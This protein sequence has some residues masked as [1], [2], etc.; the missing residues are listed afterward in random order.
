MV[1]YIARMDNRGKG[2]EL[3]RVFDGDGLPV[4]RE[5]VPAKFR[6]WG[7]TPDAEN[8]SPAARRRREEGRAMTDMPPAARYRN[9][10]ARHFV[11]S[12]PIGPEQAGQ[13]EAALGATVR[14]TFAAWGHPTLWA[15]HVEHGREIHGHVIIKNL[16]DSGGRL[17]M[18]R[19]GAVLDGLR[20]TLARHCR[21]VGLD[22]EATRRA[23]RPEM[24]RGLVA[25]GAAPD[26]ASPWNSEGRQPI[27]ERLRE[28]APDWMVQD[29]FT[30][31][32]RIAARGARRRQGLP[33]DP[34]R[35][36]DH[37]QGAGEP[38]HPS[39]HHVADGL[40][41]YEQLA[42]RLQAL[43]VFRN[44]EDRDRTWQALASFDRLRREEWWQRRD[45][46]GRRAQR[47]PFSNWM[48]LNQPIA[49]G[50]VTSAARRMNR[51]AEIR[52]A[53]AALPEPGPHQ[54]RRMAGVVGSDPLSL[55]EQLRAAEA[56]R[57]V[58][59]SRR[60]LLVLAR[61]LELGFQGDPEAL[62]RAIRLRDLGHALETGRGL[63]AAPMAG[64][65]EAAPGQPI[66]GRDDAAAGGRGQDA[67]KPTD[68][69]REDRGGL[70]ADLDRF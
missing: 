19:D 34:P 38:V 70:G 13:F 52:A 18:R 1:Y 64:H 15:V 17:R 26:G 53:L 14:D 21:A 24:Q 54:P 43:G 51:D 25:L 35:G 49:L 37:L 6:Q 63:P 44:D 58:A 20:E 66:P 12:A 65:P 33:P 30:M 16:R 11:L 67:G 60:Q 57:D 59:E 22:V 3:P 46:V 7:L 4:A 10:Q 28:L 32:G 31:L 2:D 45:T 55:A 5:D 68:G 50:P 29:G 47:T 61:G 62:T 27:F 42:R 23:D 40:A 48:L 39:D 56:A 69:R 8:L 41:P 36:V 9:V